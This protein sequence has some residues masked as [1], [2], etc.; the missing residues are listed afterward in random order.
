M[1]A[2]IDFARRSTPYFLRFSLGLILLWIGALKF[3]DPSPVVGLLDAS[4]PFLASAG[5]VYFLGAIELLMALA[6][7][8][9]IALRFVL[10]ALMGLFAG[11]LVIFVI[12]P[13][14]TYAEGGFPYLSLAGE[15]LLKDLVLFAA[16]LALLA[17]QERGAAPEPVSA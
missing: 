1:L 15:F 12:A 10:P 3:A 8:A 7:F 4:L 9:G 16:A 17:L 11:T 2:W 13:A 14:V 5:F 6:L